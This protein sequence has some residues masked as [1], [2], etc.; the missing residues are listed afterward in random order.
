MIST[1]L[2]L[3]WSVIF[4]ALISQVSWAGGRGGSEV[5]NGNGLGENRLARAYE[6]VY[7]F[8]IRV[9]HEPTCDS[10]WSRDERAALQLLQ[11][12]RNLGQSGLGEVRYVESLPQDA[13]WEISASGLL[14]VSLTALYPAQ[15]NGDTEPLTWEEALGIAFEIAASRDGLL[16]ANEAQAIAR[17]AR[18]CQQQSWQTVRLNSVAVRGAPEFHWRQ[19]R[20]VWGEKNL[21]FLASDSDTTADLSA[22]LT[23]L[24]EPVVFARCGAHSSPRVRLT[25]VH[26]RVLG[27][28]ILILANEEMER[29]FLVQLDFALSFGCNAQQDSTY[30]TQLVS[31][32]EYRERL[33]EVA[34]WQRA[35][36]LLQ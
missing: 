28:N 29:R 3:S 31:G 34:E 26:P 14:V 1:P 8:V 35:T 9:L 19:E 33:G 12:N 7:E 23:Q 11:R 10:Q 6:Q 21:P 17:K 20:I 15:P 5:G 2:R 30:F 36:G 13:R 32:L 16:N 22:E 25:A 18:Q 24:V 4:L 27:S